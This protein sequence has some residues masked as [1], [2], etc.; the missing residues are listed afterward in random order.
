M[1]RSESLVDKTKGM[2]YG[3]AF[4]DAW[5]YVTEFKRFEEIHKEQTAIPQ[6]LIISDDT[7]MSIYNIRAVDY[8]LDTYSIKKLNNIAYDIPL[9]NEIRKIFAEYHLEWLHDPKNNRAPGMTCLNALEK[10]SKI[11]VKLQGNEG[12]WGNNSKGCGTIMRAP[13]LGLVPLNR[14]SIAVLSILQSETTHAHPTASISSALSSLLIN[15]LFYENYN[16]LGNDEAF[17]IAFKILEEI[18]S[19]EI[20]LVQNS[21][22]GIEEVEKSLVHAVDNWE[23]FSRSQDT[24]DINHF[25]GE[26]WIA[27]EA[28][29]NALASV[30]FYSPSF[31]SNSIKGIKRLVYSN[32]DSDSIA[33]IGGSFL[34]AYNGYDSFDYPII[35]HIENY[36]QLELDNVVNI[37][38]KWLHQ[39]IE[40]Y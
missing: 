2:V 29:M 37:I 33:A 36:Y 7:Q 4:G 15:D 24:L 27:E 34:G 18:R 8:I 38:I 30:S 20:P 11:S 9:Q 10:Y 6:E 23:S 26:G 3:S 19:I 13:W 1:M 5:G 14:N 40:L 17:R 39:N 28:L 12:S 16:L 32:G 35:E 22:K 31:V 21:V 25:F